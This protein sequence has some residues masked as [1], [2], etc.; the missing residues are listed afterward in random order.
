MISL[1]NNRL[2]L[3]GHRIFTKNELFSYLTKKFKTEKMD[4]KDMGEILS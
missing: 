1:T 2:I 3:N 4:E